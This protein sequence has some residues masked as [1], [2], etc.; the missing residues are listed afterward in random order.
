MFLTNAYFQGMIYLPNLATGQPRV[1]IGQMLVAVAETSLNYFIQEYEREFLV[2][3]LGIRLY[4]AFTSGMSGQD[5]E[6]WERLRDTIFNATTPF[7]TSP[8]ANYV[9]FQLIRNGITTTTMKGEVTPEQD[10]AKNA[11]PD[12]R[13]VMAWNA[14]LPMIRSIRQFIIDNKADYGDYVEPACW[15]EFRPIN[16]MGI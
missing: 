3:L 1:G 2:R 12:N 8:A 10:Y 15:S 9:Y 4:D 7:P 5:K 6:K 13:L 11:S 16:R 14:M